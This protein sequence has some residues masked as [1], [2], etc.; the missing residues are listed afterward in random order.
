MKNNLARRK[1]LPGHADC[2]TLNAGIVQ[3]QRYDAAMSFAIQ[4]RLGNITAEEIAEHS[5]TPLEP[6][7]SLFSNLQICELYILA[8]TL[9]ANPDYRLSANDFPQLSQEFHVLDTF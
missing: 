4:V 7:L 5:Q 2:N 6:P 9:A 8:L 3:Q 1:E